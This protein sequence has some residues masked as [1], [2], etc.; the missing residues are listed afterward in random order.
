MCIVVKK[1]LQ[2]SVNI[3]M[4][5]CTFPQIADLLSGGQRLDQLVEET[6]FGGWQAINHAAVTGH[7]AVVRVLIE[8]KA[9]VDALDDRGMVPLHWAALVATLVFFQPN[10]LRDANTNAYLAVLSQALNV[11]LAWPA[12]NQPFVCYGDGITFLWRTLDALTNV[13][14]AVASADVPTTT[15]PAKMITYR[16]FVLR[17]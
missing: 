9:D 16:F 14:L 7:T 17:A 3:Q 8:S 11:C 1:P 15:I 10:S 13:S 5:T 6:D 2:R 4:W 12:M